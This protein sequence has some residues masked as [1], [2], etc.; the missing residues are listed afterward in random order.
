MGNQGKMPTLAE[1]FC[2]FSM[3]TKYN[4]TIGIP[5]YNDELYIAKSL[6]SALDQ[7]F[8][9][10]IEIL[11][12]NDC[13]TDSTLNVIKEVSHA[14]QQGLNVHIINLPQNIGVGAVRNLIIDN[15]KG[16]YLYFLDS[17]DY[18]T[19]NCISRLYEEAKKSDA[20]VVYGSIQTVTVEGETLNTGQHF[21]VQPELQ[22]LHE[23]GLASYAF[24]NTHAH[25]RDYMVNILF[26]LR[27]VI[28]HQ[29]R[30]PNLRFHEDVIFSADLVPLVS[31]AILLSDITYFYVIK[32]NS[33]SNYQGRNNIQLEEIANFFKLYTYIKEKNKSLKDKPYYEARCARSMAQMLF[34][35]CGALKNRRIIS[36][37]LTNRMIKAA[38]KHP[39][40][41]KE[42]MHF[43]HHKLIN[44]MYYI[45]GSLPSNL[46][47]IT[48]NIIARFKHLI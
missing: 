4:V 16:D 14:H 39:A 33:L 5:V 24:Q 32:S 48:I 25:L 36:P 29:L 10:E 12:I 1:N 21:L 3:T 45:I 11:I 28:K 23:D 6:Q 9:G 19:S 34:I 20:E 42:I 2:N 40:S 37:P 38:M 22:L 35:V 46:S 44:S 27:F 26:D 8:Q 18:I 31:R 15:A 30:Y 7:D 47:V 41:L 17:D 43:K 13:S